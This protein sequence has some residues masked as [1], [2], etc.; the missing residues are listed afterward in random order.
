MRNLPLIFVVILILG[1]CE[2]EEP[3]WCE[4]TLYL[5]I[6]NLQNISVACEYSPIS[7]HNKW[8]DS[9]TIKQNTTENKIVLN[10]NGFSVESNSLYTDTIKYSYYQSDSPCAR[11]SVNA[12]LL[13]INI[14]V[15]GNQKIV[16]PWSPDIFH[17]D[18]CDGCENVN[19]DT[20]SI[21]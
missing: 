19:Y 12:R 20:I 18:V 3:V 15:N 6:N 14:D 16:Y 11:G 5:T 10:V 7:D 2:T 8:K 13:S 4:A 9:L 17:E 21:R 1:S